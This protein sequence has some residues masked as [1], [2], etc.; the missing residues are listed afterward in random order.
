MN[1]DDKPMVLGNGNIAWP[2]GW[3]EKMAK[4]YRQRH[5]LLAP[6]DQVH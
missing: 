1:E 6:S 4:E 3:T 2:P 5:G